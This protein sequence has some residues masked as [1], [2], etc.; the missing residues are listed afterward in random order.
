M[1][2]WH[3]WVISGIS[4]N[5]RIIN[6]VLPKTYLKSDQNLPT[7]YVICGDFNLDYV[8]PQLRILF[9]QSIRPPTPTSTSS[10]RQI[11]KSRV[12]VGETSRDIWQITTMMMNSSKTCSTYLFS[13]DRFSFPFILEILEADILFFAVVVTKN[14]QQLRDQLYLRSQ[15]LLPPKWIQQLSCPK[16]NNMKIPS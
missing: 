11:D 16:N 6:R 12:L 4:Q 15:H 13:F 5:S 2:P 9:T 3:W 8:L 14:L 1:G 10:S 7:D